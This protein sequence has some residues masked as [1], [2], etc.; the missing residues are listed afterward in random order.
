MGIRITAEEEAE[1]HTVDGLIDAVE[2]WSKLGTLSSDDRQ[3]MSEIVQAI[4]DHLGEFY[5]LD[6]GSGGSIITRD[7]IRLARIM[8]AARLWK[9]RN[10]PEGIA[11][12]GDLGIIRISRTDPDLASLLEGRRRFGIA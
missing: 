10:S 8:W 11:G 3:L 6:D 9:R 12:F 1:R 5:D 4:D 7:D 2:Q